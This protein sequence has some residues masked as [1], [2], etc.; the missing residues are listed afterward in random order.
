MRAF[1]SR[2]KGDE[3]RGKNAAPKSHLNTGEQAGAS[4]FGKRRERPD[5]DLMRVINTG[6]SG[7]SRRTPRSVSPPLD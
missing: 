7:A 3:E 1:Q 6:S 5:A 4:G 2:V